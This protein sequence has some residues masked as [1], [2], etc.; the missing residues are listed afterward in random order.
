MEIQNMDPFVNHFVEKTE[1][2]NKNFLAPKWPFRMVTNAPT[3]GGKTTMLLNLIFRFLHI[4]KLFIYADDLGD[5]KYKALIEAF[6]L[7][8]NQLTKE[9]KRDIKILTTSNDLKKVVQLKDIDRTKQN[10]Y[11]FD[12]M[13]LKKDK[14]QIINIF[15]QG[16][17]F[18][19]SVIFCSHSYFDVPK[20]MR[21][22]TGYFALFKSGISEIKE[23]AKQ[24]AGTVPFDIFMKLYKEIINE[25]FNFMLIDRVTEFLPLHIR[26]GFEGTLIN[27]EGII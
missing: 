10:L 13:I 1:Y 18:N 3:G 20:M 4:D 22:Q 26:S 15:I 9:M 27:W 17:K 8:E 21:K 14:S 12:D 23:I 25:P 6:T 24:Q 2:I 16:R 7:I 11:I 19:A 5:P